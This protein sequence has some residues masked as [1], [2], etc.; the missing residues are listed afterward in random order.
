MLL[1]STCTIA[2]VVSPMLASCNLGCIIIALLF[3]ISDPYKKLEY[4]DENYPHAFK[5]YCKKKD[6][7][8]QRHI[9]DYNF[10]IAFN[11]SR[12]KNEVWKELEKAELAPI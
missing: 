4:I 11:I 7:S 9:Y 8:Y 3:F 5:K 1:P 6:I 10:K 2:L 12:I